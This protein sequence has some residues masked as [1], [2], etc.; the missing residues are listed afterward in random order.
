MKEGGSYCSSSKYNKGFIPFC[1][2]N[3]LCPH[4]ICVCVAW[5]SI[6][7]RAGDSIKKDYSSLP[8]SHCSPKATETAE[9]YL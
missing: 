8:T 6:H 9:K 1:Q 2:S 4:V 5:S 3:K 7:L